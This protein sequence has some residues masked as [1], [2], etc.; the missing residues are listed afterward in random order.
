M[1]RNKTIYFLGSG[2]SKDAGGP[3]QNEIIATL[4][5]GGFAQF[6]AQDREIIESL[7]DFKEFLTDTLCISER[8][9][10][11]VVLEDI[12]TPIDRCI[13]DGKSFANHTAKDLIKLRDQ[14]HTLLALSIQYGSEVCST[15]RDYI[16]RFADYVKN[17]CKLKANKNYHKDHISLITTNWDIILDNGLKRA[18]DKDAIENPSIPIS[19]VD[20]CCY[21]SSL[22]NDT[23][24]IPGLLALGRGGYNI[25]YLKLHG[26]MNWLQCPLCQRVYVKYYE[27]IATLREGYYCPHCMLNFGMQKEKSIKL[28]SDLLLPTFIKDFSNI[29][30]QLIWQNAQIELSEATKIVFIGFSLAPADYEIK[31]LLSRFI[32]KNAE[33]EVVLYPGDNDR[34]AIEKERYKNLFG[35]RIAERSF[36][37][38]TVPDYI[39]SLNNN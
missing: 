35:E 20:Y 30:T 22:D 10:K 5:S 14:F 21:I 3:I 17:I 18:I 11:D 39:D 15:N 4:L 2:F 12:F 8:K 26:S 28:K 13:S 33:I 25:K 36:T 32:R 19:V 7:C 23:S 1:T 6:Y 9:H 16:D 31:Q 38:K 29:Q 27:K 34:L 24:V 37:I